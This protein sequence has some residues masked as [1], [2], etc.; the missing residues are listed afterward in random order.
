MSDQAPVILLAARLIKPR[1]LL[2]YVRLCIELYYLESFLNTETELSEPT[3]RK[4]HGS[5]PLERPCDRRHRGRR[6]L[7]SN[8]VNTPVVASYRRLLR[9]LF[10]NSK[11]AAP[12]LSGIRQ[13][14]ISERRNKGGT[15]ETAKRERRGV[16]RRTYIPVW[17][18]QKASL[19]IPLQF[20]IERP[21]I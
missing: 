2:P 4:Y 20:R 11:F 14:T 7:K 3:H 1:A 8:G 16:V 15:A 9:I 17:K 18:I 21:A 10:C 12:G 13:F 5:H 6:S 19:L